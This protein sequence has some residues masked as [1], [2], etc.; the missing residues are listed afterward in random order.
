MY[1]F[2]SSRLVTTSRSFG[3]LSCFLCST[4]QNQKISSF[5]L[6]KHLQLELRPEKLYK[7][8]SQNQNSFQI[9]KMIY[10]WTNRFIYSFMV[11]DSNKAGYEHQ[12]AGLPYKCS[13]KEKKKTS[14]SWGKTR[15]RVKAAEVCKL[16]KSLLF[17]SLLLR[18]LRF[19]HTP[20]WQ[21]PKQHWDSH[22]SS[23]QGKW[24]IRW[25]ELGA[26][27]IG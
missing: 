17:S 5:R 23:L 21:I 7:Y 13:Q 3:W 18:E 24:L 15:R 26:Y 2:V 4:V 9:I 12:H 1:Y 16:V 8:Y 25:M 6:S 20:E 14:D 19:P 22:T 10:L 27:W 11:T